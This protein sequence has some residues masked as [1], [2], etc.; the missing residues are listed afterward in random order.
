[1]KVHKITLK[2]FWKVTT[3]C[4]LQMFCFHLITFTLKGFLELSDRLKP[5]FE[6]S[7]KEK[8][9]QISKKSK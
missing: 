5:D 1:M 7:S 2:I 8:C 3:P 9:Y 4:R 6:K